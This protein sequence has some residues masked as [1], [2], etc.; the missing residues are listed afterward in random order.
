LLFRLDELVECLASS[1]PNAST[2][3][4][5]FSARALAETPANGYLVV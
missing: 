2:R 5:I 1:L 4:L 3:R